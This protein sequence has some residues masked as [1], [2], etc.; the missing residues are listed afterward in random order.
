MKKPTYILPQMKKKWKYDEEKTNFLPPKP[1]ICL[2]QKPPD[3]QRCVHPADI[4]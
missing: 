1:E 2:K 4:F 3:A